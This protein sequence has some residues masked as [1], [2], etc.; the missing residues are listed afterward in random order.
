M[1]ERGKEWAGAGGGNGGK[2]GDVYV[3]GVSDLNI[4]TKHRAIKKFVAQNG[5]DGANFSRQGES[6]SHIVIPLPIGSVIINMDT[7]R[8]VELLQKGERHIILHGG[9]GGLGNE[10]FKGSTNVRPDESTEGKEG[11]E[12]QFKVEINLIADVGL[13]GLPNAGKSSLLNALTRAKAKVGAY[14]FTT[15]D[16][17]LGVF[18]GNVIADIPGIIEGASEGKGLGIKF[19][20]H[21]KRTKV[22]LHLISLEIYSKEANQTENNKNKAK[23]IDKKI[24]RNTYD[25]IRNELEKYGEGLTDKPEMLILTKSDLVSLDDLKMIIAEAKNINKNIVSVTVLDDESVRKLGEKISKFISK[26]Q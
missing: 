26:H 14:A 20:K 13:I 8:K 18:H 10:Y 19:L 3:E 12:A 2:G 21:V 7:G 4:L 9:K 25:I 22:L 5:N 1:H 6:G 16:P 11:E 17:N 24:I 15:L 23:K